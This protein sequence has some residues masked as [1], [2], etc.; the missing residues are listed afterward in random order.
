MLTRD[1]ADSHRSDLTYSATWKQKPRYAIISTPYC[2]G[3]IQHILAQKF[4][5]P[6]GTF[7]RTHGLDDDLNDI[8]EALQ[9]LTVLAA[10]SWRMEN[11]E[12]NLMRGTYIVEYVLLGLLEESYA[13][14]TAVVLAFGLYLYL[15]LREVPRTATI[16]GR[17]VKRLRSS[18]EQDEH[19]ADVLEPSVLFW[20]SSL[21]VIAANG[22]DDAVFFR[23]IVDRISKVLNIQNAEDREDVLMN[24]VWTRKIGDWN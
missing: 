19:G 17:T 9:A 10:G 13:S 21:G 7:H 22:A 1:C 20:L 23:T 14:R 24:V 4:R 6:A 2:D 11:D 16:L 12:R 15:G 18:F 3:T 8:L 5:F